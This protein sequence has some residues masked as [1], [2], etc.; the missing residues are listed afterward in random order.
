MTS[1]P[2]RVRYVSFSP[3][4]TAHDHC[5][6]KAKVRQRISQQV[7]SLSRK[8]EFGIVVVLELDQPCHC[9]KTT[10]Q[11]IWDMA[12]DAVLTAEFDLD[13]LFREGTYIWCDVNQPLPVTLYF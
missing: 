7:G 8:F 5:V 1:Q 10:N 13:G 4:V 12:E 9:S 11:K 3:Q 6:P 2:D